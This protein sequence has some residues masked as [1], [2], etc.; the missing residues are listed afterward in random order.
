MLIIG[1]CRLSNGRLN[2]PIIGAHLVICIPPVKWPITKVEANKIQL[3]ENVHQK[4]HPNL[5]SLWYL[6][7][8][9]DYS[10]QFYLP[11]AKAEQIRDLTDLWCSC[12]TA[13]DQ[14]AIL[15]G[16][17]RHKPSLLQTHPTYAQLP[18]HYSYLVL[19]YTKNKEKKNNDKK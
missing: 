10:K 9:K 18:P 1:R 5:A 2:W 12:A 3:Q 13:G 17:L 19:N 6:A 16:L 11:T 8:C 7:E 15:W 4:Q 14:S